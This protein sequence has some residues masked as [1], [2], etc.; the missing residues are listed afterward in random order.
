MSVEERLQRI[1]DRDQIQELI[2]RYA[3][4]LDLPDRD[5]FTS[6]WAPDAVYRVDDPFG[7][8]VGVEAIGAAWDT[9]QQLFPYMYH[10]TMNVVIDGPNGDEAS[11][12]SFAFI[13][14]SDAEGVAWTSSCTYHDRFARIDGEWRFTERYDQVNYMVPWLEPHDGLAEEGRIYMDLDRIQRLLSVGSAQS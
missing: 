8:T 2:A 6:V 14:G 10:H 13:T 4:G 1:E 11:A 12:V 9:F 3:H 7:E 5:V